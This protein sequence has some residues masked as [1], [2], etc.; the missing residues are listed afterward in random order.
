[1]INVTEEMVNDARNL[2][3]K[4]THKAVGYRVLVKTIEAV[5]GLEQVE[6]EKHSTLADLGFEV[7]TEKQKEKED[8]GTQYGIAVSVGDGSFKAAALGGATPV[9]EG[10]VVFFDR[11]AGVLIEVPPGSG[12]MYRLM[13]DESILSIMEAK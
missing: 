5:T 12:E 6:K 1:M 8:N 7:K 3:A 13:N 10:D 11:Y 9:K 2:M 4:G